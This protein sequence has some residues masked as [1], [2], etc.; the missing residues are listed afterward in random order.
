[1]IVKSSSFSNNSA[2]RAGAILSNDCTGHNTALIGNSKAYTYIYNSVFDGNEA[3]NGQGGHIRVVGQSR[4]VA[5][6]STFVNTLAATGAIRIRAHVTDDIESWIISCT[7]KDNEVA[8]YNQSGKQSVYNTLGVGKATQATNSNDVHENKSNT[9]GYFYSSAFGKMKLDNGTAVTNQLYDQS[10]NASTLDAD[11]KL[12]DA[13]SGFDSTLG[14]CKAVAAPVLEDGMTAD[15]L[16]ELGTTLSEA[17]PDFETVYLTQD[18]KGNKR[19]AAIMG[20]YV[21]E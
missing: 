17:M 8:L 19:T 9:N 21:G 11:I 6:N 12:V 13:L 20:A 10:G 18:Q 7:F 3:S 16:S 5:V 2:Y 14:V 1:M 4:F 15:G